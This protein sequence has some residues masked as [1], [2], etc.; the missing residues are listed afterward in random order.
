MRAL[1]TAAVTILIGGGA[2]I[3]FAGRRRDLWSMSVQQIGTV[4]FAVFA[5]AWVFRDSLWRSTDDESC[6]ANTRPPG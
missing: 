1:V 5:L 3:A 4:L 6:L 2:F